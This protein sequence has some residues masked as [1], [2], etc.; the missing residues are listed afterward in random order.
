MKTTFSPTVHDGRYAAASSARQAVATFPTYIEAQRAVD[1]L[2]DRKFP[3]ERVSI[4]AEGIRLVEY[5]TGR[6]NW[7]K[8]ALNGALSGATIGL[9]LGVLFGLFFIVAPFITAFVFGVY[10]L[11]AGAIFGTVLGLLGYALSSG[12]RDFTSFG[13]IQADRYVILVEAAEADEATRLLGMMTSVTSPA[14][15]TDQQEERSGTL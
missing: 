15:S 2:S 3:V 6:L 1:Y 12:N 9:F 7:G 10:G 14:A 5:V 4:V 8:A 13:S 11:I